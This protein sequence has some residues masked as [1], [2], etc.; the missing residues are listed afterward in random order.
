VGAHKTNTDQERERRRADLQRLDELFL[1]LLGLGGGLR[2][3]SLSELEQRLQRIQETI[4]NAYAAGLSVSEMLD[5][6]ETNEAAR[7]LVFQVP[8]LVLHSNVA[9]EKIWERI[10]NTRKAMLRS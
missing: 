8:D 7:E 4:R 1:R 9:F 3:S 5:L 2:A 6:V 10:L